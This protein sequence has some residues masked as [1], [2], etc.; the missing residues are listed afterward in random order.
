MCRP[1]APAALRFEPLL[2]HLPAAICGSGDSYATTAVE[3]DCEVLDMEAYALAKACWLAGA[4]FACV[5]YVTDGA[6]SA[7]A[8]DW[9]SNVHRAAGAFLEL[10]QAVQGRSGQAILAP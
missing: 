5:K 10:Y 2:A 3:V 8:A 6:D 9:Q 4:T 7:A 1:R